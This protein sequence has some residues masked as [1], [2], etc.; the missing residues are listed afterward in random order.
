MH[1]RKVVVLE[2]PPPHATNKMKLRISEARKVGLGVYEWSFPIPHKPRH[3]QSTTET[4]VK[5]GFHRVFT[6]PT[7]LQSQCFLWGYFGA[8]TH[9]AGS[10][11]GVGCMS[12]GLQI[13]GFPAHLRR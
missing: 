7:E 10:G 1:E 11:A 8:G 5:N 12:L 6:S 9:G 4:Q 3:T 2:L 13:G